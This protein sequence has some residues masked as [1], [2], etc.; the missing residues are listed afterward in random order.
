MA[1]SNP[2]RDDIYLFF[3]THT[4]DFLDSLNGGAN[5]AGNTL[6]TMYGHL[7][8]SNGDGYKRSWFDGKDRPAV[9]TIVGY[10]VSVSGNN[11]T[12]N[13][14][15]TKTGDLPTTVQVV[16]QD[17]LD[18]SGNLQFPDT[19]DPNAD[20]TLLGSNTI[21]LPDSMSQTYTLPTGSYFV[22]MR[23]YNGFISAMEDRV[24]YFEEDEYY[25]VG[26]PTL[27][28]P[29]LLNTITYNGSQ[30][31]LEVTDVGI[32]ADT[33]DVSYRINGG[34]WTSNGVTVDDVDHSVDPK[35]IKV[36]V[37]QFPFSGDL[38]EFRVQDEKAGYN[39]SAWSNVEGYTH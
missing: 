5:G 39:D 34:S 26:T 24:L 36:S 3:G 28:A 37:N 6:R 11:V 18:G 30:H 8:S 21:S 12:L 14:T 31:T 7:N 19:N 4:E 33:F 17:A 38:F 25:T 2:S 20:W 9:S 35:V 29:D 1:L 27:A 16:Y 10:S 32:P 15:V 23:Y 22:G 13:C